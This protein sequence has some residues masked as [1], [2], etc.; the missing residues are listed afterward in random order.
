MSLK[1]KFSSSIFIALLVA[2]LMALGAC[3]GNSGGN[4]G[5]GAN[6]Q[7][8]DPNQNPDYGLKI[9]SRTCFGLNPFQSDW[10]EE[11]AHQIKFGKADCV[12]KTIEQGANVNLPVKVFGSEKGALPIFYAL[13]DSALFFAKSN[14]REFAVV[15]VL[16]EAG[17]DLSVKGEDGETP[18]LL[19]L[20]NRR[21][22]TEYP[23]IPGYL[24]YSGKAP[25]DQK[26]ARGQ[27]PLHVTIRG[28]LETLAQQLIHRGADLNL[29]DQQGLVPLQ[30]ALTQKQER[31]A[32][33]LID[34]SADLQVR[35]QGQNTV[36][37]LAVQANLPALVQKLTPLL[38]S[39]LNAQN[40]Q[41]ETALYLATQKGSSEMLK[42]LLD[43]GADADLATSEETPLHLALR[44]QNREVSRLLEEKIQKPEAKDKS[45][46]PLVYVA[47][48]NG[49]FDIV[50]KLL[51][52]GITASYRDNQGRTLLHWAVRQKAHSLINPLIERGVAIDAVD[53]NQQ[54]ALFM[55]VEADDFSLFQMLVQKGASVES[56]VNDQTLLIYA[57]KNHKSPQ[58]IE[59][60]IQQTRNLNA[61][62]ANGETAL[63]LAVERGTPEQ[64]KML[65]AKGAKPDI[66]DK[67]LRTPLSIAVAKDQIEIVESL[68]Q[69]GAQVGARSKD[70]KNLMH[71]ARSVRMAE[72]L[73]QANVPID[74]ADAE[75][76]TPLSQAVRNDQL[77]LVRFL[78]SKGANVQWRS[79]KKET[80]LHLAVSEAGAGVIR[81]LLDNTLDP[82]A[83]DFE[84]RSPL[85]SAP[86]V[87]LI[88]LL[89]RSGAQINMVDKKGQSVLASFMRDYEMNPYGDELLLI[90]KLL[91]EG[92][93]P[94]GK[95]QY[96]E[97]LF[98]AAVEMRPS[99]N[100]G[101]SRQNRAAFDASPLLKKFLAS[102]NLR[103]EMK[104]VND[105]TVLHK[106][107]TPEE[108]ELLI[109]S[110][111]QLNPRDKV[112]KE[113]PLKK[114]EAQLQTYQKE[115]QILRSEIANNLQLRE[116]AERIGNSTALRRL[117]QILSEQRAREAFL[118]NEILTLKALV[119][120]L[121]SKGA[122][123]G[124]TMTQPF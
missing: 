2:A 70:G 60:L 87:S 66:Q 51:S 57:L 104:D 40:L 19:A 86:T 89:V 46:R 9:D 98:H 75:G 54:T 59:H 11:L 3:S 18:L 83:T 119:V 74:E 25:L 124:A 39:L 113:T 14:P 76:R 78:V 71:V 77:E 15:K 85:F 63:L 12:K 111:V 79:K 36:L 115:V 24:I 91:L 37:H 43:K 8:T 20:K 92:A 73:S 53:T 30:I 10:Q 17:A 34:R 67:D 50:K 4:K 48:V 1:S 55:A 80:L 42:E 33:L 35:D 69:K 61:Q 32:S 95:N 28:G 96:G 97:F 114:K 6:P 13:E 84:G 31:I 72:I 7:P 105:E 110:G 93:D 41:L 122:V 62:N 117:D 45:G 123:D 112:K 118:E 120:L 82:N 38:G 109:E 21:I 116:D 23:L 29:K 16:V 90:E 108:A 94:N 26:D 81:Y 121:E 58:I 27:T 88:D 52:K 49:D 5:K 107:D 106:A 44:S 68:L 101:E 102:S 99:F 22:T 100:G 65:L 103:I 64:V 56:I 47:L